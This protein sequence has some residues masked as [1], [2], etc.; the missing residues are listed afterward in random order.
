LSTREIIA[1]LI[2][3]GTFVFAFANGFW[4]YVS[5]VSAT[6]PVIAALH[7]ALRYQYKIGCILAVLMVTAEMIALSMTVVFAPVDDLY[8]VGLGVI[9]MVGLFGLWWT[10][11]QPSN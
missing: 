5:I 11:P 10:R 6:I 7:L 1:T 8:E 3:A 9:A 2:L 4:I